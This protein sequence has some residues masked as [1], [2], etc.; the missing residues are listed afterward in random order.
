MDEDDPDSRAAWHRKDLVPFVRPS[1]ETVGGEAHHFPVCHLSWRHQI[2]NP[3]PRQ[4]EGRPRDGLTPPS[5]VRWN[6]E[7]WVLADQ[8]PD[9]ESQSPGEHHWLVVVTSPQGKNYRDLIKRFSPQICYV[10]A[11]DWEEVMAVA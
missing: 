1:A 6:P 8:T 7:I 5:E 9:G 11:W 2:R 3:L 4:R 10:P